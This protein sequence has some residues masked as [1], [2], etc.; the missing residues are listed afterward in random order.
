MRKL[1]TLLALLGVLVILASLSLPPPLWR[2]V[3][4]VERGTYELF[5]CNASYLVLRVNVTPCISAYDIH[6]EPLGSG[7]ELELNATQPMIVAS[8]ETAFELRRGDEELRGNYV[9]E[10]GGVIIPAERGNYGL[11]VKGKEVEV[12]DIKSIRKLNLAI[13]KIEDR[14]KI[15]CT[16]ERG[17]F[18]EANPFI[19]IRGS[20]DMSYEVEA[21]GEVPNTLLLL[22]GVVSLTSAMVSRYAPESR[23]GEGESASGESPE[24]V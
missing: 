1:P 23:G 13:E 19:L 9:L 15:Y 2:K 7:N 18:I 12:Y 4:V 5:R 6:A 20:G 24:E 11:S 8:G 16:S 21:Y 14:Y 22:L 10:D 17:F 3:G